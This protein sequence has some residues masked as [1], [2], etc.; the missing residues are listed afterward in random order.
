MRKIKLSLKKTVSILLIAGMAL[1]SLTA[2]S[3]INAMGADEG[4]TVVLDN[5]QKEINDVLSIKQII[6][7]ENFAGFHWLGDNRILGVAIKDGIRNIAIYN[8]TDKTVKNITNNKEVKK[9]FEYWYEQIPCLYQYKPSEKYV[10]F[11]ERLIG[12]DI[13]SDTLLFYDIKEDKI[14]TIDENVIC[15]E[16]MDDTQIYYTKGLSVYKYDLDSKQ[17]AEIELP[18]E[19][20]DNLKD[21]FDS[22]EEY[23]E[24]HFGEEKLDEYWR[25]KHKE[26]YESE[27]KNNYITRLTVKGDELEIVSLNLKD[28]TLNMKNNTF[29]EGSINKEYLYKDSVEIDGVAKVIQNKIPRELWKIDNEGNL[30]KLI[31]KTHDF[32][33]GFQLSPD[34]SKLIYEATYPSGEGRKYIYDFKSDKKLTIFGDYKSIC[35]NKESNKIVCT[36]AV[37]FSKELSCKIVILND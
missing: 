28:Y 3:T 2:C 33:G 29:K 22:Y 8:V 30:V 5:Q 34:K 24:V 36:G 26:F 7:V 4:K 17:K 19:L 11:K 25:E 6:E 32:V 37:C 1:S 20:I 27:K 23:K 9:G 15:S 35:W 16:L 10:L 13:K 18:E 14:I 12:R 31:D 21:Y